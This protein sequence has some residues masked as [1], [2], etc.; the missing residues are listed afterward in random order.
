MVMLAAPSENPLPHWHPNLSQFIQRQ[1]Q[2]DGSIPVPVGHPNATQAFALGDALPAAHP[3]VHVLLEAVLP[4]TH[5]AIDPVM[6][7]PAH[8]PLPTAWGH[9]QLDA[10]LLRP[11]EDNGG[12]GDG[13]ALM[14]SKS[15]FGVAIPTAISITHDHPDIGAA[16]GGAATG[17]GAP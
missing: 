9:P 11:L 12:G 10:L 5:P 2:V 1:P 15:V 4:A 3:P 13:G 14:Q 7:D 6:A 8:N 16:Y 17:Y